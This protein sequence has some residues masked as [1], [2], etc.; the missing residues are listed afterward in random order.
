MVIKCD[1][2]CLRSYL[3]S[4]KTAAIWHCN[5]M[6]VYSIPINALCMNRLH[7]CYTL[8]IRDSCCSFCFHKCTILFC[9][10]CGGETVTQREDQHHTYRL[11]KACMS[12]RWT[13][14]HI[15]IQNEDCGFC[16]LPVHIRREAFHSQCEQEEQLQHHSKNSLSAQTGSDRLEKLWRF[17]FIL[18]WGL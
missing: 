9:A 13:W 17:D 1:H 5:I 11:W 12:F 6:S 2:W 16:H 15:F 4:F 3:Q 8:Q 18:D 7:I 14:W 10:S